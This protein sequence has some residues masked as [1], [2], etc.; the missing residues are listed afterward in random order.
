MVR[1]FLAALLLLG[2]WAA[3]PADAGAAPTVI[4]SDEVAA[5]NTSC[6]D[7]NATIRA[8]AELLDDA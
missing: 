6:T 3:I 2:G 1:T 4:V 8:N 7:P 5:P